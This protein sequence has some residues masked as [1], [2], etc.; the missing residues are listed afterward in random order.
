MLAFQ[1]C[2]TT[3][4]KPGTEVQKFSNLKL[5]ALLGPKTFARRRGQW[6]ERAEDKAFRI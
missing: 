1:A 3:S 5:L 2:E 6:S 4:K